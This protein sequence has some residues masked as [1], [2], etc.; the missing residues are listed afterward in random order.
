MYSC[1]WANVLKLCLK[2]LENYFRN[3]KFWIRVLFVVNGLKI[4]KISREIY[5][6]IM[7]NK[8]LEPID[9][10]LSKDIGIIKRQ[11]NVLIKANRKEMVGLL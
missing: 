10:K 7:S 6:S 1:M 9:C 2:V 4:Y 3:I 5:L 11:G 8:K